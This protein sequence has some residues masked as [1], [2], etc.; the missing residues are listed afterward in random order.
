MSDHDHEPNRVAGK[1][2]GRWIAIGLSVVGGVALGGGAYAIKSRGEATAPNSSVTAQA[3]RAAIGGPFQL[4]NQDGRPTNE[5]VLRGK[6]SAVFFGYTSCPDFCPATLQTL[7]AASEKLGPD[8]ARL[9][10]VL[11]TVDPE[12]D[13]PAVLKSYLEG[14][15]FPGGVQGLTGTREQ[16]DAAARVWRV[17]HRKGPAT[18]AHA[19]MAG[20]GGYL[21]DHFTGVFLTDPEGRFVQVFTNGLTPDEAARQIRAAMAA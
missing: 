3:G 16:V 19:G 9:Q 15:Q 11:I 12:R 6:W 17:Y 5:G 14:Y 18:G 7:Q 21:I 20:H 13:T 1:G 2:R 8:A 4:V 10:T